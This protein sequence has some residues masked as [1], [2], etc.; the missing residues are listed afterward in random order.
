[1]PQPTPAARTSS[2][3]QGTEAA[4]RLANIRQA[5]RAAD[6]IAGKSAADIARPLEITEVSPDLS[7]PLQS[8]EADRLA[9]ELRVAL[10]HI[11]AL[12]ARR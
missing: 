11:E 9:A 10:P 12:L 2:P 1:M 3:P 6:R 8:L 5:L 4:V 7:A